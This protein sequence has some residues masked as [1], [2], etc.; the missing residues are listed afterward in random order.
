MAQTGP[1]DREQLCCSI[2]LEILK[3]PVALPCGHRYCMGCIRACWGEDD[4]SYIFSCP[5]CRQ[6]F[7]PRPILKRNIILAEMVEKLNT[8]GLQAVSSGQR[9]LYAEAGDVACDI[10]LGGQIKATRSCLVCLASYCAAHLHTHNESPALK[11]HTLVEATMPLQGRICSHHDRLLEIYCRTDQQCVCL[12]CVMDEHKSHATVSAATE[13]TKKR[14]QLGKTRK[15]SKL[16]MQAKEKEL[17]DLRQALQSLKHSAQ[18]AVE[19]SQKIFTELICSIERRCCEV[20]ELIRAQEKTAVSQTEGLILRLEQEVAELRKKDC[21][22][23]QLSHT[24]DHIYF[25]QNCQSISKSTELTDTPRITV[26]PLVDFG[27]VR[28]SVSALQKRLE[29]LLKGEWPKISRAAGTVKL[30][31]CPEPRIRPEFLYYSCQLTLDPRTAHRDLS[32]SEENKVVTVR[33]R[34]HSCLEHPERFD[35]WSQVLC[36]EALSGRCYWEAEWSGSGINMAVAY[37]EMTRRGEG[38][39]SHFGRNDKSWSLFCSRKGCTIWHNN[40]ATRIPTSTS[41]RIGVYL[42]HRA[43]SLC[44]YSVSDTMTLLHRVQTTFTQPLYLGFEFMCFGVFVKLC[45]ME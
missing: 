3:E 9:C 23:E 8:G 41:S 30:L 32:V 40:V 16:R 20:R 37:K 17:L 5:Q 45:Q 25:L 12:L 2:C 26:V 11:K 38:N 28:A 27:Q 44:F 34:D 43:G 1:L 7:T 10:C 42:D 6:T 33:A 18:T 31:Q 21:E 13:S 24:E 15:K 22:L 36:T 35:H 29:D 4:S 39:D 19:D 14:R